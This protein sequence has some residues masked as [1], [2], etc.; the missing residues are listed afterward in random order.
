MSHQVYKFI[1]N[2]VHNHE[3]LI[4]DQISD[5]LRDCAQFHILDRVSLLVIE[6]VWKNVRIQVRQQHIEDRIKKAK[7]ANNSESRF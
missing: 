2:Q 5:L 3:D 7:S 6:Q 1:I 4:D